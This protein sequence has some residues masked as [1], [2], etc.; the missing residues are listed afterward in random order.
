MAVLGAMLAA[1]IIYGLSRE[2]VPAAIAALVGATTL[3][4]AVKALDGK[5]LPRVTLPARKHP[6]QIDD[7]LAS[8]EFDSPGEF[9]LW[10]GQATGA[11]AAMGHTAGLQSGSNI[12]LNL[13]DAAKNILVLGETGTGKTTRIINH[14]VVQALDFDCGAFI[15]D[16]RGDFSETA[17]QAA[18]LTGKTVQRV[19]IGQLGVNL[20]EGLTADTAAG[21]LEAAFKLLGQGEGDSGFWVSLAVVRCKNA[22]TVLET[23]P[24]RYSLTGLYEYVF[25]DQSRRAIIEAASELL[26]DL[27]V[28]SADGDRQANL[29]SRRIKAALAYEQ[30]VAANYSDKERSGVNRTIETALAR[31]A[32]PELQDAFCC[33]DGAQARIADVLDG[34]MFIVNVPR[35]QFKAAAR[36]VYLFL[37]ERFF[38]ALN[39]RAQ[40]AT[41]PQ[42][43]RPVVFL[44]D[45]YQQIVSASDA[46]FF[47]TSRALNV[48]GIVASQ[49]VEAFQN[50]I[51]S[52]A[53]ASTLL[54]N[55]T[56]LIA[57]RSTE[58]TM[59]YVA[60]KL[61]DVDVWKESYSVGQ[62]R[63]GFNM[64]TNESRSVSEHRHRLLNAQTFRSMAPEQAVALLSVNGAAFDDILTVPQITTSDLM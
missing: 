36:V 30:N 5:R 31:F 6:K 60:A 27:Q 52:E 62:S 48:I 7:P 13:S 20:L 53:A 2:A 51:G 29:A 3:R 12:T 40:M 4:P 39:T 21:I 22:L 47:D 19:G 18:E 58:K 32:D 64:T 59:N 50:A 44:C 34:A 11:L 28:R 26:T 25:D 16:V 17:I 46:S 35:E 63:S 43:T 38:Q 9:G 49:S 24:A 33:A 45:E 42:K 54:A 10:I 41:G 57:F 15:F 1:G 56:N 37:K 8:A 14:L 23:T 61:G 55:F